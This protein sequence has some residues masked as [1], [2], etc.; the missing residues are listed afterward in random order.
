MV[1]VMDTSLSP[2]IRRAVL[3]DAPALAELGA[4]T[5]VEAFAYLYSP[6]DLAEFLASSH[7]QA[8]YERHLRDP[9]VAIWLAETAGAPPIGYAVAGSC[10]LPVKNL[11]ARAGEIRQIYVRAA[12]HKHR[13][14]TKLLVTALDWLASQNRR[15]LYVGVWSQNFGAQRLYGRFGFEKIGEYEFNVGRQR[16]QE[17]ILRQ[18]ISA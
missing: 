5:F 10:K 6:E 2:V 12:F 1:P 16:D 7:S 3:A 14:G 17:F 9:A 11:E 18:N 8:A 15:P 13:L 4:A